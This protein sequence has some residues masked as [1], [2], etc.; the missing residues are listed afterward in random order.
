MGY[1][2]IVELLFYKRRSFDIP[3]NLIQDLHVGD[4][5]VQWYLPHMPMRVIEF[6]LHSYAEDKAVALIELSPLPALHSTVDGIT[7][8]PVDIF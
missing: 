3:G 4:A 8:T 6:F 7:I 1:A 2:H 5:S